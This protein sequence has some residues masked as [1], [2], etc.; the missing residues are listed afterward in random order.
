MIDVEVRRRRRLGEELE[1][2]GLPPPDDADLRAML[3]EEVDQAL[4]PPVHERRA[5]S[6]GTILEPRA[7]RDTW[8][9]RTNLVISCLPV[10]ARP[11]ASLRKLADGLSSWL[12]RR[13]IGEDE[14]LLF[15]RPA[16]SERDLIVLSRALDATVVQRHPS[17]W[18][19]LVGRF[20]VL[21]WNGLRWHHEPPIETWWGSITG[22]GFVGDPG[23][24]K[25]LAEFA[26][27]DLGAIGIGALLV[28]H[29]R[30]AGTGTEERL[31]PPPP[32][33]LC[34]PEHLAPLRHVLSQLDGAALFNCEGVLRGLGVRLIPSPAA[35]ASVEPLGGTRHTSAR[36]Y[37]YDNPDATVVAVSEDGPVTV[38]RAGAVLGRS[39][40]NA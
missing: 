34:V 26:I 1:E 12:V 3:L 13:P 40:D 29:P 23:V 19:R 10:T 35:E 11:V 28:Y 14:W 22:D 31:P 24:M 21:R 20:G 36:R 7:E 39:P 15:D 27:H 18:V 33:D 9:R 8:E 30:P 5:A 37:S 2:N 16:G 38:M 25:A 4:R 32:L 17:G 6:S